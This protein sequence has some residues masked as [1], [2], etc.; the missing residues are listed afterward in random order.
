MSM[1]HI[2]KWEHHSGNYL[3]CN[4][5]GCNTVSTIADAIAAESH[6]SKNET[7]AN[8]LTIRALKKN[9]HDRLYAQLMSDKKWN[10]TTSQMRLV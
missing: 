2:H 8:L 5:H 7:I 9:E 4:L 3:I 6:R 10:H 1:E